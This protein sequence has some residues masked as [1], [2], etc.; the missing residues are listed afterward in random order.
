MPIS[1]VL[2]ESGSNRV[3]LTGESDGAE[4]TVDRLHI[5]TT[6]GGTDYTLSVSSPN[7]LSGDMNWLESTGAADEFRFRVDP[8]S[9]V[10]LSGSI[11][12][13]AGVPIFGR[14]FDVAGELSASLTV[15]IP[16][17]GPVGDALTI[18][19][20]G[21]IGVTGTQFSTSKLC[22][23]VKPDLS[24]LGKLPRLDFAVPEFGLRL[25]SVSLPWSFGE[26][27][28]PPYRLPAMS[29]DL[30]PLPVS[31][32]FE[33]LVVDVDLGNGKVAI[34]ITG[35][36]ITGRL[37]TIEA[38][39]T[40]T[41][42]S[43][44]VPIRDE[45]EIEIL[46]PKSI[47]LSDGNLPE[48][49]FQS[50]DTH[51][52]LMLHGR[53]SEL[54]SLFR[55]LT[56]VIDTAVFPNDIDWTIR[57]RHDLTKLEEVRLDV[58]SDV[59]QTIDLPGFDF[60]FDDGDES[61]LSLIFQGADTLLCNTLTTSAEA[62]AELE[63][64][65][66]RGGDRELIKSDAA[67]AAETPTVT[68]TASPAA[69]TLSLL[70]M[71]FGDGGPKFFRK[72]ATPLAKLDI[73][74]PD[75]SCA[76]TDIGSEAPAAGDFDFGFQASGFDDFKLPFLQNN[77][78]V[79][80]Q[81]ISVEPD[82]GPT[83]DLPATVKQRFLI[84]VTVGSFE[85]KGA[86][87]LEFELED[88]S[89]NVNHDEGI[90]I[91]LTENESGSIF[92][93]NYELTHVDP[94][95]E[96]PDFKLIT[97]NSDYA[98]RQLPA[99]RLVLSFDR[100]T[101]DD[102]T[103][104]FTVSDFSI[105]S[106]GISLIAGFDEQAA[107]LNSIE[108]VFRF[109]KGRLE[110]TDNRVSGFEIK[111]GG[112]LP[113]D[114]VGPSTVNIGLRFE[115]NDGGR[116]ELK[117]GSAK[118]ETK[119]LRCE[120]TRFQFALTAI[121]LQFVEEDGR[122][123]LY[124]TLSGT[125]QYVPVATDDA[126]GPLA[127]MPAVRLDLVDCPLTTDISVLARHIKFH[128]PLPKK[129]TFSFLGCFDFELRAIGF[130]PKATVFGGDPVPAM[131]VSGQVLFDQDGGD[132]IDARVDFH[133]LWIGHPKP[134]SFIPRLHLK[135][136]GVKITAGSAFE[137][138]GEVNFLGEGTDLGG[139]IRGDGF[140]GRGALQVKGLPKFTAGF[141]FLR[142][143]REGSDAPFVRAWF[144]YFQAER[145]SL[146]V[147]VIEI[148]WREGGLGFGHRFT[149]AMIKSVDELD[150]PRKLLARLKEQSKTQ[151]ELS[152]FEQW[153]V[154][155]EE[156]GESPRWTIALRAMFSQTSAAKSFTD[157]NPEAERKLPC[158]FLV[159]AVAA[160][161]S[162]LTFLMVG[163][164]W[165]WTNYHDFTMNQPNDLREH[166]LLTGFLLLSPRKKRFLANLS[167]HQ[168]AKFGANSTVIQVI[169]DAV[170]SSKFSAT[171]LIEPGL[172]HYELGW[173]NQLQWDGDLGPLQV[174]F[175]GGMI[176]RASRTEFVVGQSFLARGSLEFRAGV[177]FGFV[178]ARLVATADVAY[179]ARYIGVIAFDDVRGRS[180]LYGG[181]G[182][183]IN[184]NVM[185]EF[186][187]EIDLL[188]GSITKSWDFNFNVNFTASVE[189]GITIDKAL[190]LRGHATLGIGIMGHD[191]QFGIA[192]VFN[193][194]AV[195]DA[196]DRTREF[197]NIG[198][199]AEEVEQI[200]GT[201]QAQ[202]IE[203]RRL[204]EER[205]AQ[206]LDDAGVPPSV[207]ARSEEARDIVA[208]AVDSNAVRVATGRRADGRP[209]V[210]AFPSVAELADAEFENIGFSAPSYSVMAERVST[211][212]WFLLFP[213]AVSP[214]DDDHSIERGLLHLARE[215][216][217]LPVPLNGA[218][219]PPLDFRATWNGVDTA[220][221]LEQLWIEDADSIDP[222]FRDAGSTSGTH[223]WAAQ[224]A[225]IFLNNG[226]EKD[227]AIPEDYRLRHWMRSA[228][229]C[230]T[231][232]D[233]PGLDD[234]L[235]TSDPMPLPAIERP[236]S[237]Q[238]VHDPAESSF[239][240]AV[241]GAVEQFESAPYF[242]QSP[243]EYDVTLQRA[244]DSRAT[245]YT[246][247][248]RT[249]SRQQ[250]E[251]P[252]RENRGA[253]PPDLRTE[254]AHHMRGLIIR[255]LIN[256]FQ[257]ILEAAK[258]S[259]TEEE[260]AAKLRVLSE[261][262][263]PIRMG[264]VF[265][266][267]GDADWLLDDDSS[268]PSTLEQR[269]DPEDA[270]SM[271]GAKDIVPL[272]RPADS[273]ATAPPEF[274]RVVQYAHEGS[275][276]I[277]WELTWSARP[278][279]RIG[280]ITGRDR[281]EHHLHHYHVRRRRVDS[282]AR[283]REFLVR[284]SDVLHR[285]LEPSGNGASD[286]R[287]VRIRPRFQF[288]DHFADEPNE[289]AKLLPAQG[290]RYVYTITPVDVAGNASP[291]PLTVVV[292]RKPSSPPQ[293][294]TN[295][296]LIVDYELPKDISHVGDG[297]TETPADRRATLVDLKHIKLAWTPPVDN[298]RGPNV[299]IDGYRVL[300]RRHQ[301]LPVGQYAQD[302]EIGGDRANGAV[303]S[304]ARPMRKDLR[305]EFDAEEA[306]P[307]P[308]EDGRLVRNTIDLQ[309][310]IKNQIETTGEPLLPSTDRQWQPEGWDVYVQTRSVNGV[311]SALT[312]VSVRLR[313]CAKSGS[314]TG[315]VHVSGAEERRPGLLEWIPK[316]VSLGLLPPRD[317]AANVG[318]S[319]IPMPP[320]DAVQAPTIPP[321][322]PTDADRSWTT[323]VD[324]QPPPDRRRA[325]EFQWNQGPSRLRGEADVAEYPIELHAGYELYEFDTDAHL[326]EELN[327]D[328]GVT[329][330]FSEWASAAKLRLAQ[331]F[332][333]ATPDT[334][335]TSPSDTSD[336]QRWEA[337][338][339]SARRRLELH[340][341]RVASNE[342]SAATEIRQSPWYSWRDSWLQWPRAGGLDLSGPTA[343][344]RELFVGLSAE[345]ETDLRRGFANEE[346]RGRER[347]RERHAFLD[348]L[349]LKT[350]IDFSLYDTEEAGPRY[351]IEFGTVPW[352][353]SDPSNQRSLE[354]L[355]EDTSP[356][357]DPYGWRLLQQT[358]LATCVTFRD[359]RTSDVVP[360]DRVIDVMAKV[361]EQFRIAVADDQF[362]SQR[363]W[364]EHLHLDLLFRPTKAVRLRE[365]E[366]VGEVPSEHPFKDNQQLLGLV[367]VSLRPTIKRYARYWMSD[368]VAIPPN[369]PT[370]DQANKLLG[371]IPAEVV[372]RY[373]E[374]S[375]DEVPFTPLLFV[376]QDD[377]EAGVQRVEK[378]GD[379][380][381]YR[382]PVT[383]SA[384]GTSRIAIR[385][386][387]NNDVTSD[388]TAAPAG[389]RIEVHLEWPTADG[390][391]SKTNLLL[392]PF[393]G[394][395]E[396]TRYFAWRSQDVSGTTLDPDADSA[397]SPRDS[398]QLLKRYVDGITA[399]S[400]S[401]D[402]VKFP[403]AADVHEVDK[404]DY[405]GP[406]PTV[407][408][409][410]ILR[411]LTRFFHHGAVPDETSGSVSEGYWLATSWYRGAGPIAVHPDPE[412]G[413]LRHFAPIT[414]QYAHAW[415]YLIRPLSRYERLWRS[416]AG[417]PDLITKE[418]SSNS[419]GIVGT[420]GTEPDHDQV[421]RNLKWLRSFT[422]PDPGGLD[423]V[424][425]R[426]RT[427]EPPKILFSGRIDLPETDRDSPSKEPPGRTWQLAIAKHPEQSLSE[428]N[429]TVARRLQY[430]QVSTTLVRRFAAEVG[431]L[432]K[433]SPME[434]SV[435]LTDW[436][437]SASTGVLDEGAAFNPDGDT[438]RLT[439]TDADG[440][441]LISADVDLAGRNTPNG[442]R[443]SLE[444]LTDV[445]GNDVSA[446]LRTLGDGL[447]LAVRVVGATQLSILLVNDGH[448]DP[449]DAII[450]Q[451]LTGASRPLVSPLL[452]DTPTMP[453]AP[454]PLT[455]GDIDPAGNRDK[456]LMRQELLFGSR[457]GEFGTPATVYEW[458]SL[459][460]YYQ[461]QLRAVA[462]STNV[463][464]LVTTV[465]QK[466]FEY[467]APPAVAFMQAGA[468]S[469]GERFRDIRI[470][471]GSFHEALPDTAKAAWPDEDP[472]MAWSDPANPDRAEGLPVSALPDPDVI[473]QFIVRLPGNVI[474]ALAQFVFSPGEV[475][476]YS[477]LNFPAR[478]GDQEF[479]TTV[480]GRSDWGTTAERPWQD[481]PWD[482]FLQTRLRTRGVADATT[483]DRQLTSIHDIDD[484]SHLSLAKVSAARP[485]ALVLMGVVSAEELDDIEALLLRTAES[486]PRDAA[487]RV[488]ARTFV[489][490]I[491]DT[492][493]DVVQDVRIPVSVGLDQLGEL[494]D[495]A[496]SVTVDIENRLVTW[497][498]EITAEQRTTISA[499]QETSP[500]HATFAALLAEEVTHEFTHATGDPA[501]PTSGPLFGRLTIEPET[502]PMRIV[503]TG[504]DIDDDQRT[505][506]QTFIDSASLGQSFRDAITALLT[507]LDN[508]TV[509]VRIREGDW[510]GRPSVQDFANIGVADRIGYCR[511]RT[512]FQ[513]LMLPTERDELTTALNV[514]DARPINERLIEA[515]YGDTL[516]GGFG[517]ASLELQTVRG[518]AEPD[519]AAIR[520]NHRG[521][522]P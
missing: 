193:D 171:L 69:S 342:V 130:F 86:I 13:T 49:K 110:V 161:R 138:E 461:H 221:V 435:A 244:F 307:T 136:L 187:I 104:D 159:D 75:T 275:A 393:S 369:V 70:V 320:V 197:L 491:R 258:D 455:T 184:V 336:T 57:F 111:G 190:G 230:K 115:Q 122:Y 123:H 265:R 175:R 10:T 264:L 362:A 188:F 441:E 19:I 224:W 344:P 352:R 370:T 429:R 29:F 261:Q 148:F 515:L 46:R 135:G 106:K 438:I 407:P 418:P 475:S 335:L 113:P 456:Q 38:N 467:V 321:R 250:R 439:A 100:A 465:T 192:I 293:T 28:L 166:P 270:D 403:S 39:V 466:D 96:A 334:L 134:G 84:T 177:D 50:D 24:D 285:E 341:E 45:S 236:L 473:Y 351:R 12:L 62:K 155:L 409:V 357:A 94:D 8:P 325:I 234:V 78:S 328:G 519:R 21:Q 180:A 479:K 314:G 15:T 263:L 229:E 500:S 165:L 427:I 380:R 460:F 247:G 185:V 42:D 25:P 388:H 501:T 52:C 471:L 444:V 423:V 415:R 7:S 44:G 168:D 242:K 406:D 16:V 451:P 297:D 73:T 54:N 424:V 452:P 338:Y 267:E 329:K 431:Q 152:R 112:A 200:P 235:P 442:A 4:F 419:A 349:V 368:P 268:S 22:Y 64:P 160:V 251:R 83:D 198:L 364:L 503:W 18:S 66:L 401:G 60:T 215:V 150:D 118:L 79:F 169:E 40:L 126:N 1:V 93:L 312:P 260:L 144:L 31:V 443:D 309:E 116:I 97:K 227:G 291:R 449:V 387:S 399:G 179:G 288:V 145:F 453:D 508:E 377:A 5:A 296:E 87:E 345:E 105:T 299:A 384:E 9:E 255:R 276:A 472:R 206:R 131:R 81:F 347:L 445:N 102:T 356:E 124:F 262:S 440:T 505:E 516:Q 413:V 231:E 225:H 68:I 108:Q 301:V 98:L 82:G 85:F 271:A 56:P 196:L 72:L 217:F 139:G 290:R 253:T 496:T 394:S 359:P 450:D 3:S 34:V 509:R 295:P 74:T 487:L 477:V 191:I 468:D 365:S 522:Q 53:G 322:D 33:S 142:V 216:G 213:A 492:G 220:D 478:I 280:R 350:A 272:R 437:A 400:A 99:S 273:F 332:E 464:S 164:A 133:D 339:P 504:L 389:F 303:V 286:E 294:V 211:K 366:P 476:G 378:D 374:V 156:P 430:W 202:A 163:R 375:G 178:G 246:L 447:V 485:P 14:T 486:D 371:R 292:V 397:V 65:W 355:L 89:F 354:R 238:R 59:G 446:E 436:Y 420:E 208:A 146:K 245:L 176:V 32:S 6:S 517:G 462:Q 382:M 219:M 323:V 300:F 101:T 497:V 316:P 434:A 511:A 170:K 330:D 109:T 36:T 395:D 61:F 95:P 205:V 318:F 346:D 76:L 194:D 182:I 2:Y 390:G 381:E 474:Q 392:S 404:P 203:S 254:Q 481:N 199:E 107:K 167:S 55:V 506:L 306:N 71:K 310:L 398:W 308:P 405:E 502:A 228:F 480:E 287:L 373:G 249:E 348:W 317:I 88:F 129:Q 120:R 432:K 232:V 158:L 233:D 212:T 489:S 128:I 282:D 143:R 433:T 311:Y 243:E 358:G 223:E 43:S 140:T 490:R 114:L 333:L 402:A 457:L 463:K 416:L 132:A 279:T 448:G 361:L 35:L 269:D 411:W 326:A 470:R 63:F 414:D 372:V 343:L 257:L 172:I 319:L 383:L 513:G 337:W 121:G 204:V 422:T 408:P 412:T 154:D 11:V 327:R 117:E 315:E 127:W 483:V 298:P 58:K 17:G 162:D 353:D 512:E 209:D 151:G 410:D 284:A 428:C 174:Q 426:I 484:F 119:G 103:I 518:S 239:E 274:S 379:L 195:V 90:D 283:D 494:V 189:V 376:V 499:W 304:H 183:E 510:Q 48:W 51:A 149:L 37:V 222:V 153:R 207:S 125:A 201:K 237:D 324:F 67:A 266:C 495:D 80:G 240:S 248:G 482:V 469:S 498:G 27:P 281:P 147:P 23:S 214:V 26:L 91:R 493:V 521:P 391:P 173:P 305:L 210:R 520:T 458:R 226:F 367:Q 278:T 30:V 396:R 302:G 20:C 454:T 363:E 386:L 256:D 507:D 181:A 514:G 241:R 277:D 157:W 331:Q 218:A 77:D 92:G 186:W 425:D 421:I 137:L 488:A 459:P 289:D 313:F 360:G 47:D 385:S 259:A 141:A 41:L 417:S 340:R 252:T